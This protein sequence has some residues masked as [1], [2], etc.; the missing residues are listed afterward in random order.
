MQVNVTDKKKIFSQV[1]C[2]QSN[3]RK[4]AWKNIEAVIK[5]EP[6]P[7]EYIIGHYH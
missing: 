4:G 1:I 7:P 6:V 3:C 5:C 2:N